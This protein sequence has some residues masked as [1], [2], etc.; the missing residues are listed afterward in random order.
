MQQI[1]AE[2]LIPNLETYTSIQT[3]DINMKGT[4]KRLHYTSDK[5]VGDTYKVCHPFK[6]DTENIYESSKYIMEYYLLE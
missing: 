2:M 6:Y 4:V 5:F 1:C 3:L